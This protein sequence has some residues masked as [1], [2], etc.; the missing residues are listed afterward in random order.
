MSSSS[1]SRAIS[2]SDAPS[3]AKPRATARPIPLDAPVMTIVRW[4]VMLARFPRRRA[5]N[6]FA[7]SAG[8]YGPAM[9]DSSDR[10]LRRPGDSPPGMTERDE[11]WQREK[12]NLGQ[13]ADEPGLPRTWRDGE[14][15]RR[16]HDHPEADGR[17]GGLT[18]AGRPAPA[19]G[20]QGGGGPPRPSGGA[21]STAK[22]GGGGLA[23]TP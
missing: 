13:T 9:S 4:V 20:R 10:K 21:I 15:P 2:S 1:G 11:A 16:N 8:G 23:R 5:A 22:G 17:G 14:Q 19:E 7:A 18:A 12:Q 6:A 3:A